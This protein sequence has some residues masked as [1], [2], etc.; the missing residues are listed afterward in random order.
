MPE[1]HIT[2]VVL[3]GDLSALLVT[4]DNASGSKDVTGQVCNSLMLILS[5]L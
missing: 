1:Q 4:W 5:S 2:S 3:G